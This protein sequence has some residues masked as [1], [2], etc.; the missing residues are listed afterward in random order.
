LIL[1]VS[2]KVS[3]RCLNDRLLPFAFKLAE[4]PVPNIR[5]NFAKMVEQI[6]PKM[7]AANQRKAEEALKVMIENE[8]VDF[9]VK[10]YAERAL[11]SLQGEDANMF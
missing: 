9:D 1:K 11:K 7:H 8:K 3:P 6:F 2:G 5:F 10:Y 4:D